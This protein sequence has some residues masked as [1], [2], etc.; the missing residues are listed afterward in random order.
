MEGARTETAA[1]S[2]TRFIF[3]N[4]DVE[5]IDGPV[6]TVVNIAV[7]WTANDSELTQQK[8]NAWQTLRFAR[9]FLFTRTRAHYKLSRESAL[10]EGSHADES[11]T[12]QQHVDGFGNSITGHYMSI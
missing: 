3:P 8:E 6:K 2:V 1:L 9:H 11:Y 10:Y 5:L 7:S 4:A 12:Q